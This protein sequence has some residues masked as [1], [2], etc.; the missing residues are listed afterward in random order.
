MKMFT[1]PAVKEQIKQIL[2]WLVRTKNNAF[3]TAVLTYPTTFTICV[4]NKLKNILYMPVQQAFFLESLAINPEA[5]PEEIAFGLAEAAREAVMQA[6]LKGVGE[7]YFLGS[8]ES[9][10]KFAVKN[11]FEE[12]PF[13]LYRLKVRDLDPKE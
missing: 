10:N 5:K 6:H 12:V 4:Y 8:N 9:T 3:D 2:S 1:K 13:K 11:G 7:V